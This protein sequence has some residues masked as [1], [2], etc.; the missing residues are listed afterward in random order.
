[1]VAC[2]RTEGEHVDALA[3][4]LKGT[5]GTHRLI[6]HDVID[7]AAKAGL[8]GLIRSLAKELSPQASASTWSPG[9]IETEEPA[10]DSS[11]QR[12][13]FIERHSRTIALRRYWR[14]NERA[15]A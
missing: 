6:R 8:V 5:S 14:P 7:T 1:M 11:A 12:R 4:Q 13:A 3:Q 2:Y 15:D 10:R 9:A